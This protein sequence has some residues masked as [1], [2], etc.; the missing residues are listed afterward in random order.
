MSF[1]LKLDTERSGPGLVDVGEDHV[2]PVGLVF[3]AQE[4]HPRTVAINRG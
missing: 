3:E 2:H 4:A 1:E